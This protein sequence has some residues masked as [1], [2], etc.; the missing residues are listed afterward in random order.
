[1]TTHSKT[2]VIALVALNVGLARPAFACIW[3]ADTLE[4]EK[5]AHPTLAE[6]ILA[7]KEPTIDS[8]TLEARITTLR[9]RPNENDVS[10]SND[11]GGALLRLGRVAE[12]IP[13]LEDAVKRFPDDYGAHA[14]LGTAYH[15]A[16]RFVEGEQEIRRDLAINPEGHDGLEKYHL[17]L[18]QYL[19]RSDDYRARHVYVD[20]LSVAYESQNITGLPLMHDDG[21]LLEPRDGG[22]GEM[23][24]EYRS[25]WNLADDP[26]LDDGVIYM[27][28]LNPKTP[29]AIEML[30][31]VALVHADQNLAAAAFDR[32]AA[33]GP[34]NADRLHDRADFLRSY[35]AKSIESEQGPRR[36]VITMVS[37]IVALTL[38]LALLAFL[39]VRR[40]RARKQA[41]GEA[42]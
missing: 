1:M 32:A 31:V 12:A 20:E 10:W 30:G 24:P 39:L 34:A 7:P 26:K 21:L 35:V 41:A 4:D 22:T 9:A 38:A 33:L 2:I 37:A 23:P 40:S 29:A 13:L 17:A 14:N 11:L 5:K 6:A 3:D 28:T 42:A 27:A 36:A 15:L 18:L 16:G 19:V 8:A 25:R